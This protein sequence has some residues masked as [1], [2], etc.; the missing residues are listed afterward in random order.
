MLSSQDA[1]SLYDKLM[2]GSITAEE[3]S[4]SNALRLI[5]DSLYKEREALQSS[6]T[7]KLWIVYMDMVDILRCF[8]K[9]EH[10]GN[11]SLQF[12]TLSDMLPNLAAAG[13]N[14]YVKSVHLYLQKMC[15]LCDDHPNIQKHF[16]AGFHCVRKSDHYWAGLSTGFN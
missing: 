1:R 11:W 3:V 15:S 13:H 8:L 7:A 6:R 16:D 12:K 10:C 4:K 5:K 14:H 2:G 9:A